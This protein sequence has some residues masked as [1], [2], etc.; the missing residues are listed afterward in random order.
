MCYK[1]TFTYRIKALYTVSLVSWHWFDDGNVYCWRSHQNS[2]RC[3]QQCIVIGWHRTLTLF[4]ALVLC[5]LQ[6]LSY[7][8][9]LKSMTRHC[10][11]ST[12]FLFSNIFLLTQTTALVTYMYMY[13][14]ILNDSCIWLPYWELWGI[15]APGLALHGHTFFSFW[16]HRFWIQ[17]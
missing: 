10:F 5:L 6:L 12:T 7:T 14:K 17:V 3:L 13:N 16:A 1:R 9:Q 4:T 8:T 2:W 11:I 15:L